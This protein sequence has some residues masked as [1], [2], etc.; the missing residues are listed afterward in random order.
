MLKKINKVIV[1]T[2]LV[3]SSLSAGALDDSKYKFNINSLV[4]FEGG[5]SAFDYERTTSGITDVRE[6]INL[7]HGGIKIG[8][9][10][11]NYRLFLSARAFDGGDFDYARAYGVEVQY[12]LNFS[13]M[14]NVYFGVNAGTVDMRFE[15]KTNSKTVKLSE[16]YI[17]GDVGVNIHLGKVADL[18]LGAR[19]MS[20]NA[21]VSDGPVKYDFDNIASAYVSIIFKYQMD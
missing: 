10:S 1:A 8:A 20:L 9:E 6:T 4:G 19:L 18:E 17:G 14:A 16:P 11:D 15:D 21:T 7:N 5:Y 3:A 12:L 2:V 13:K